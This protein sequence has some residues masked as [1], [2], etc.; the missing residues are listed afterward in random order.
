MYSN[1]L[2]PTVYTMAFD[3]LSKVG[4]SVADRKKYRRKATVATSRGLYNS[5][6]TMVSS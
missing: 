2:Q 6:F 5:A 3:Y 1:Y 4:L